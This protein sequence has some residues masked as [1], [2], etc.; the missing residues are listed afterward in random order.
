MDDSVTVKIF[1][2]A[3]NLVDIT[4]GFQLV[5]SLPSSKELIQRLIRA[6]LEQDVDV[7]GIFKEVLEPD[8]IIVME[9]SVDF[10]FRHE[11]L[12]GP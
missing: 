11:L 12:L 2:G 6:E 1:E 10:D 5:E 4:L 9:R 8:D 7:L 3:T